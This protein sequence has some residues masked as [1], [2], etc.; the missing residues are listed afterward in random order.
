MPF[1]FNGGDI[2]NSQLEGIEL[3]VRVKLIRVK[4]KKELKAKLTF[5]GL[6]PNHKFIFNFL[7][8]K[9]NI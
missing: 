2:L 1:C 9:N 7:F 6:L 4:K 8:F 5:I 3:P